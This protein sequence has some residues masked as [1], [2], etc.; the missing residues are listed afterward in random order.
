MNFSK[1]DFS[2]LA[3]NEALS[4]SAGKGW[5]LATLEG[6]FTSASKLE[7]ERVPWSNAISDIIYILAQ[8]PSLNRHIENIFVGF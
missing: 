3:G 7:P 5:A 4:D 1:A 2:M 6:A 8:L